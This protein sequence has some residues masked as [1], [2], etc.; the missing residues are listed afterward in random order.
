MT[1]AGSNSHEPYVSVGPPA[2]AS[3]QAPVEQELEAK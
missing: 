3:G 1:S 2:D